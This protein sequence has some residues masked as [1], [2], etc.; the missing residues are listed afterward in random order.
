MKYTS[1]PPLYGKLLKLA[2]PEAKL[3][4]QAIRGFPPLFTFVSVR[5]DTFAEPPLTVH[6]HV[7]NFDASPLATALQ[8][9]VPFVVGTRASQAYQFPFKPGLNTV[10]VH[11]GLLNDF[12]IAVPRLTGKDSVVELPPLSYIVFPESAARLYGAESPAACAITENV[13]GAE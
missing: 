6:V 10:L 1:P 7:M 13:I 4:V 5:P 9:Y 2:T 8:L 11:D 3:V 12:P